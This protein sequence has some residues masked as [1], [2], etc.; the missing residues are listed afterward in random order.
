MPTVMITAAE[1]N[2]R[3]KEF[4]EAERLLLER[5]MADPLIRTVALDMMATDVKMHIPLRH[6][7]SHYSAIHEA[8][9]IIGTVMESEKGV[10]RF[11]SRLASK[12][13]RAKKTDL[14]RRW[15]EDAVREQPR[16]TE[17]QLRQRLIREQRVAPIQEVTQNR[18][19]FDTPS[20]GS[21]WCPLS[22]LKDRLS[23]A[24]RKIN[25]R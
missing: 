13:G 11:A 14:L 17:P 8:E 6:Q 24:K 22:G 25:S 1:M 18:V 16:I 21:K 19:Y 7:K 4:W 10:Q 12:G 2:R 5:G 20:G 9:R 15:I 23:R 3:N